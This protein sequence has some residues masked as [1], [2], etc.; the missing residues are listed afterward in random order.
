M[1]RSKVEDS[2]KEVLVNARDVEL[3]DLLARRYEEQVVH[4]SEAGDHY[5]SEDDR[6]AIRATE[7][8]EVLAD[9]CL[10]LVVVGG[11]EREVPLSESVTMLLDGDEEGLIFEA[12]RLPRVPEQRVS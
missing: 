12:R 1:A 8:A 6:R 4:T 9:K 2:R 10:K 3:L 11:V 5:P 7:L